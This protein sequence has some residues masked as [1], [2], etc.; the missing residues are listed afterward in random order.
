MQEYLD[1]KLHLLSTSIGERVRC[2][3]IVT[4]SKDI[5]MN[6]ESVLERL[7]RSE[8]SNPPAYGAKIAS[9]ILNDSNLREM[10]Y[11][12]IMTMSSRI[13]SMREGLY[14]LLVKNGRP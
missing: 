9:Y 12:D 5:A 13:K 10:W 4:K 14:N 8:V 7:Q 1:S 3:F 6:C 2:T 11:E